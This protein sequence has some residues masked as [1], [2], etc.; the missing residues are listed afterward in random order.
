M[1]KAGRRA[2]PTTIGLALDDAGVPVLGALER[3]ARAE[4]G[5]LLWID[6]DT[7]AVGQGFRTNAEGLRQLSVLLEPLGVRIV[8]VPLPY[9]GG[10]D[11]CL[12]LMSLISL[13]DR[14]LAVVYSPLLPVPFRQFLEQR[15]IGFVEVPEQEFGTMGSN[16][17]ALAPRE[18][19]MLEDNP[20]TR[21]RLESAGCR[22][23][24]Y[25]GA[26]I[27]HKAEGGPTC[28]TRPI[29]RTS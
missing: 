9:G 22:V 29:L 1:G 14:D 21:S 18:C 5:D 26:E 16:V 4:G 17:L 7:L 27:S 11:A 15:G 2:E 28:L 25:R 10:P 6:H 8:P 24:T 3:A 12:H 19:L 20:L 13:I 23:R